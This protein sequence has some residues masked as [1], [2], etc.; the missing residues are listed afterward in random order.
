MRKT[1]RIYVLAAGLLPSLLWTDARA[2]LL[3]SDWLLQTGVLA[4]SSR[5]FSEFITVENPFV[6]SHVATLGASISSVDY[7]FGWSGNRAAFLIDIDQ[8]A[9]EQPGGF[10]LSDAFGLINFTTTTEITMSLSAAY[11]F[12]LPGYLMKAVQSVE[13][14]NRQTEEDYVQILNIAGPTTSGPI[15]GTFQEAQQAVIPAYCNCTFRYD[16]YVITEVDAGATGMGSGYLN[17]TMQPVPEPAA[18]LTLALG[19]LL[20]RRP[21]AHRIR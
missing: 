21:C 7:E 14:Y 9:S 16:I 17:V 6:R 5:D 10:V 3:I 4:P 15:A 18:F 8:R 1:R 12:D 13:V 19:A 11:T 2:D 20:L